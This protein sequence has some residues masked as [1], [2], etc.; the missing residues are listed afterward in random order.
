MQRYFIPNAQWDGDRITIIGDDV[1][2]ISKVMRF[3]VGT[4]IIC[5][6]ETGKA[7]ICTISN[8]DKESVV[9]LIKEWLDENKELPIQVTIAQGIPKGD[10]FEL[11]LQKGTELGANQFI[12]F[13]SERSVVSWDQK[14]WSKK[15]QRFQKIVKEAS[16]QCH[17]NRIPE[18][19]EPMNLSEI[20][21]ESEAYNLKVF[22]YEEEAKTEKKE[23][24]FSTLLKNLNKGERLFFCIGPE[25]G[26]SVEEAQQLKK[27]NFHAIRLGPRILRTE[28]ASLY[29]LSSISYHFEELDLSI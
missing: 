17:R 5:N 12:P 2:H 8:I 28:T 19:T 3:N 26:F 24:N 4:E 29:A 16:E 18:I 20:I 27:N 6:D 25:G 22:A 13:Q 14:K 1:H 7:A 21:K 10:K 23:P 15:L 11:V 9:V